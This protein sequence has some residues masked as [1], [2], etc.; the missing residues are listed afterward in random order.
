MGE[1]VICGRK[2]ASELNCIRDKI[3]PVSDTL[4]YLTDSH[5]GAGLGGF[6]QQ[7]RRMDLL[8]EMFRA[9]RELVKKRGVNL[10]I[11]GG[12]MTEHGTWPEVQNAMASL[13]GM[14][15]PVAVCTG[16]HDLALRN[17]MELWTAA[18]QNAKVLFADR[19][20]ALKHCDV[21]LL[22][23]AWVNQ[24][25]AGFFWEGG[26]C[27]EALLEPQWQ[28]LESELAKLTRTAILVVHAPLDPLPPRLTGKA[29]DLYGPSAAYA[30][31]MIELLDRHPRV[32]L[33]LSGHNHV[34]CATGFPSRMQLSTA[35][36]AEP[37][38][39]ARLIHV[40]ENAIRIETLNVV[41]TPPG[42]P[43]DPSKT[44]SSGQAEDRDVDFQ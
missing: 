16:N 9:I 18:T 17:S 34:T 28:W 21:I 6:V 19:V 42:C 2:K 11:H 23:N 41:P 37:P 25:D 10:V 22:N 30:A 31:R 27:T 36:L 33:V 44:W 26:G 29:A 13:R 43:I 24:G 20:V 14:G 35:S 8:P 32:R 7:P 4:L 39:Q 1:T 12:D 15:A 5:E 38:F 3:C 40:Q